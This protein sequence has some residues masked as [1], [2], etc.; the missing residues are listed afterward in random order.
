MDVVF[1]NILVLLFFPGVCL[2]LLA[3]TKERAFERA[4]L[5]LEVRKEGTELRPDKAA[6]A[7]L[8]AILA[9]VFVLTVILHRGRN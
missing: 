5:R 3:V 8:G 7:L 9:F 4:N 2:T 6:F 1:V